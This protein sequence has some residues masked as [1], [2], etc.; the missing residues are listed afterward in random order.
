LMGY[1]RKLLSGSSF[2]FFRIFNAP[3]FLAYNGWEKV[4]DLDPEKSSVQNATILQGA[5]RGKKYKDFFNAVTKTEFIYLA[6]AESRTAADWMNSRSADDFKQF[7]KYNVFVGGT[8]HNSSNITY[9]VKVKVAFHLIHTTSM[10]IFSDDSREDQSASAYVEVKPGE[11]VPYLCCLSNVNSGYYIKSSTLS[12]RT[13]LADPAYHVRLE[14]FEGDISPETLAEEEKL[15]RDFKSYRNIQTGESIFDVDKNQTEFNVYYNLKED[16]GEITF[17]VKA[18]DSFSEQ[19]RTSKKEY[20]GYK[21]SFILNPNQKYTLTFLNKSI[22]PVI[23]PGVVQMFIDKN[24]G[25]TYE[26]KAK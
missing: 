15:I 23:R 5:E 24:G 20:T 3:N 12:Q 22:E 8:L 11:T 17:K 2:I 18:S 6:D 26:F 7:S 9:K 19:T 21:A 14:M 10:S 4:L 13:R 25:V 16:I 1:Y